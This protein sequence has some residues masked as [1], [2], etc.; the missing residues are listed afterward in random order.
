MGVAQAEERKFREFLILG[1]LIGYDWRQGM[2][3]S[4]W[5]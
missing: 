2:V 1:T 4:R 5:A 3:Y